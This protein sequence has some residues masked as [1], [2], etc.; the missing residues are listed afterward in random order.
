MKD[1]VNPNMDVGWIVS[2]SDGRTLYDWGYENED[3]QN[4]W[5]KLSDLIESNS[6]LKMTSMRLYNKPNFGEGG[7]FAGAGV[8]RDSAEG[9]FFTKRISAAVGNPDH[10]G[11]NYGIGYLENQKVY[12]TWFNDRVQALESE[13]RNQEDC[14]FGLIINNEQ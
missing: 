8:P 10:S 6:D 14:G 4:S 12:I 5:F 7:S 2:L 1:S 3:G 11:E 9:Y 13:V